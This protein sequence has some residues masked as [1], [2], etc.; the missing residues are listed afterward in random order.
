MTFK[1]FDPRTRST[2]WGLAAV[3]VG[4]VLGGTLPTVVHDLG[5]VWDAHRASLP[6]L[7]ERLA[8]FLA[9]LAMTGS[10]VYGLMLS[11]KLLDAIAHRP[12]SFA[13]HQD[14]AAV[15]LGLAGVHGALL[16]LDA[17]VPFS[18][19]QMVVPGLAPYA[20]LAVAFGQ[21]T[22]YVTAIVVASFYARRLIGQRAWRALH[23]LTFLAFA[24]ATAHGILAGTD[25]GAAWTW[26][27]Y[28]L[29]VT[30]V[31][32]LFAYRLV[33]SFAR[34]GASVRQ[35]VLR[36]EPQQVAAPRQV[37]G[38]LPAHDRPAELGRRV[39]AREQL[40]GGLG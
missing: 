5:V 38:H 16:G 12:V 23:V 33:M 1:G 10:V 30:V 39:I 22:F 9:Y 20:P 2:R 3:A 14:L 6:W 36:R 40:G 21:L 4:I 11:T 35:P 31:V 27:M 28:T 37:E 19:P 34:R 15:G 17:T 25:S 18:L 8:A 13:L 7:L 24:G 32:F 26:W 29:S